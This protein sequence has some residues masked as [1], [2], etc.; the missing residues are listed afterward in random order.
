MSAR[1]TSFLID[2]SELYISLIENGKIKLSVSTLLQLC[3]VFEITPQDFFLGKNF[4]PESNHVLDLYVNLSPSAQQ[5][6]KP[7]EKF[8]KIVKKNKNLKNNYFLSIFI[9][10]YLFFL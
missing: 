4:N 8:A 6:I 7:Y 10:F 2:K 5:S 9:L 1:E 3:E